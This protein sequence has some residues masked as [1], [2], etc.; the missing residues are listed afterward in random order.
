MLLIRDLFF[1]KARYYGDFLQG[2]EKISSNILAS[3]L[4]KLE[5]EGIVVKRAVP[6][7]P[8]RH[9]YYPT[10][11]AIGLIPA[12]VEMMIWADAYYPAAAEF[13]PATWQELKEK[14]SVD[15]QATVAAL[16]T[17]LKSQ[18]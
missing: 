11:K 7:E 4:H 12:M 9:G 16:I 1:R 6:T 14:L 10:E 8:N 13:Q 18:L 2:P 17:T 3:R 15:K 5:S